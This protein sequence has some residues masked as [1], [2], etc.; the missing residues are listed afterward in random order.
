MKRI[1]LFSRDPGGAN[2][3]IPLVAPLENS[4]YEVRL[5]G[6]DISLERYNH[7]NLIGKN[8]TDYISDVTSEN[9][10][11]FLRMEQ[12]DFIITGTSAEDFTERYLWQAAEHLGIP[13]FAILDQWVN[14]GIRFSPWGLSNSSQYE[15]APTHP[16]LPSRIIVMD[17]FAQDEMENVHV[18]DRDRIL[19]LGQPYFE[20]LFK[21]WE[22]C[23]P[24]DNLRRCLGIAA[25][26]LVVTFVSEPLAHDYGEKPDHGEYWGFTE[27]T[28]FKHVLNA[29][30]RISEQ[31]GNKFR[32]IIKLHPRESRNN[33]DDLIEKTVPGVIINVD[34][35]GD[36][37]KLIHI[38][39]LVCGMSSMMLIEAAIVG[40]PILS[41]LIG[42][43]RESPFVLDRREIIRSM[44]SETELDESLNKVFSG[45]KSV[46]GR[47]EVE[48][49]PVRTIIAEMERMLG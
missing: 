6:R 34:H 5:Y 24:V 32:L 49:N 22:S 21:R 17:A 26:E 30:I 35:G 33:Y 48:R 9:V 43:K 15:A 45:N 46:L 42:L 19:P 29:L 12:P 2:T 1:I 4:G 36:S 23:L 47:F 18:I 25:D 14:Y 10:E 13:S 31:T 8:I 7:A 20:T 38:S 41:V 3:V 40:K 27:R 16:F 44:R 37:M 11:K 28:I 39:D